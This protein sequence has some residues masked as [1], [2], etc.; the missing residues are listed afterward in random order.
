MPPTETSIEPLNDKIC[1]D[2]IPLQSGLDLR[3]YQLRKI[4]AAINRGLITYASAQSPETE[5]IPY[6]YVIRLIA[7]SLILVAIYGKNRRSREGHQRRG[8]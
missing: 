7:F 3:E 6:L 2:G 1:G 8:H 5:T 4:L